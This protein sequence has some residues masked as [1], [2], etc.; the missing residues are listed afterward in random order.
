MGRRTRVMGPLGMLALALAL[1]CSSGGGDGAGRKASPFT[2]GV[3]DGDAAAQPSGGGGAFDNSSGPAAPAPAPSAG[4]GPAQDDSCPSVGRT[5]EPGLSAVDIVWAVD[6]SGSMADEA[7]RVQNNIQ[8]FVDGIAAAGVDTRVVFLSE[9]DLVPGNSQLAQGGNYLW[10]MDDVDSSNALDRL[11]ARFP[12]YASFLRP[13]AH[14]HFII[15]TDDESRFMG[16]GTPEERADAFQ[17]AMGGMLTADFSVHAIASPGEPLDP[18]CAPESVP[19][20]IVDCCRSCILTLCFVVPQGCETH[21]DAN[22]AP[23][24]GPLTCPFLGGAARPGTTYYTLADRTGGIGASICAEDWTG[25]FGSLSDAVIESAPL[26]C[27]YPI[28]EPPPGMLL[29][30]DKVNV[31]YTPSGADSA[32]V[33][34]FANVTDESA[35]ADNAAWFY[36]DP[37]EPGEVLLCPAACEAVSA[38]DGGEV[39][40]VF[41]CETIGIL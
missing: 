20:E 8:S 3:G 27:G 14:V 21:V 17:S 2:G 6:L 37:D 1:A 23:L 24:V 4:D 36:D 30:L 19:M 35:C 10:V 7:Q 40:V 34:P 38:G 22:G 25:V 33:S 16:L 26:P 13:N 9:T 28:P 18:P 5:A 15:V 41:G 31:R 12:D 32:S 11:V 29:E 39:E